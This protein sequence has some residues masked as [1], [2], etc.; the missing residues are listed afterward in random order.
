MMPDRTSH[1]FFLLLPQSSQIL[2]RNYLPGPQISILL[3]Q[4][5]QA[6]L[7]SVQL[8]PVVLQQPFSFSGSGATTLLGLRIC[9]VRHPV[10]EHQRIGYMVDSRCL[11][12]L[13]Y[14]ETIYYEPSRYP[15]PFPLPTQTFRRFQLR[16]FVLSQCVETALSHRM[17]AHH[18]EQV[19]LLLLLERGSSLVQS[20]D[21]DILS[22]CRTSTHY[23][24]LPHHSARTGAKCMLVIPT[25]SPERTRTR[26]QVF[27][28]CC[29]AQIPYDARSHPAVRNLH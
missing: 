3:G 23:C 17:N 6:P 1:S 20:K 26:V 16:I 27:Y 9:G 4:S 21:L 5:F 10:K 13:S 2:S 25:S 28:S 18:Y 14:L 7:L 15:P 11:V 22:I 19:P 29:P 8:W 24:P 12:T